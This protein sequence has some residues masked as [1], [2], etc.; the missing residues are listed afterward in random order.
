MAISAEHASACRIVCLKTISVRL[1]NI[2]GYNRVLSVQMK[3]CY[4]IS[5]ALASPS[6]EIDTN[7][8]G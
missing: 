6:I 2:Q 4:A 8:Q 7:W 3:K 1:E 5:S